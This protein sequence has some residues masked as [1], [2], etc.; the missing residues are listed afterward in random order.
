MT[1]VM[2]RTMIKCCVKD[3]VSHKDCVS[4]M[5][6]LLKF[7]SGDFELVMVILV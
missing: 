7:V 5:G 2:T 1:F 6:I 4:K 3:C